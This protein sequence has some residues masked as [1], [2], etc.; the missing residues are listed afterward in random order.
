MTNYQVLCQCIYLGRP[1]SL[2]LEEWSS[3]STMRI[4][5]C[6]K[7][8]TNS[9]TQKT[10]QQRRKTGQL[11]WNRSFI[12]CRVG[13]WQEIC[14]DLVTK[15]KTRRLFLIDQMTQV[16]LGV[17]SNK[18]QLPSRHQAATCCQFKTLGD[19]FELKKAWVRKSQPIPWH[20]YVQSG[21]EARI[22][23]FHKLW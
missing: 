12:I 3:L 5:L 23:M 4:L 9:K 14:F 15:T 21:P 16:G 19:I 18:S 17:K 7:T 10:S 11:P 20:T 6:I 22:N 1:S 2:P 8:K 13:A